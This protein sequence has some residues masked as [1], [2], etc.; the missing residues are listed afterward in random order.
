MIL[1]SDIAQNIAFKTSNILNLNVNIMNNAGIIIGSGDKERVKCFHGGAYQVIQTGR[2][3]EITEEDCKKMQGAKPGVNLPILFDNK[4]VGV[5]GITG[6]PS[7]VRQYGQL[8]KMAVETMLQQSFLEEQGRFER[9]ARYNYILDLLNYDLS[10]NEELFIDRGKALGY[11]IK[12]PR[13][14]VA[15]S[16]KE[17][18]SYNN[19]SNNS[20]SPTKEMDIQKLKDKTLDSIGYILTDDKQNIYSF[21]R[22]NLFVLFQSVGET[23]QNTALGKN[24]LSKLA[25]KIQKIIS[26]RAD[27]TTTMGIGT[28]HQGIAGLKKSYLEAVEAITVGEKINGEGNIYRYGDLGL[29]ILMNNLTEEVQDKYLA[30]LD[31]MQDDAGDLDDTLKQTMEALFENNLNISETA[32]VLYIHRNTLLYRITKIEKITKLNPAQFNDAMQLKLY[33]LLKK[34]K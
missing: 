9:R 3:L 19:Y 13:V 34:L 4:I 18:S 32:R 21:V 33:L 24:K 8:L 11:D 10:F 27:L 7:Q 30:Q 12:I 29:G 15:V 14:A 22:D 5:V 26:I 2:S 25:Q 17:M 28:Y 16:I 23:E 20:I 31:G 6:E 1:T